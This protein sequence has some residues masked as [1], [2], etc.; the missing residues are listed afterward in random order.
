[1]I[2]SSFAISAEVSSSSNDI[3]WIWTGSADNKRWCLGIST[4]AS[5]RFDMRTVNGAPVRTSAKLLETKISHLLYKVG[6]D[7]RSLSPP[8]RHVTEMLV[9]DLGSKAMRWAYLMTFVGIVERA[10]MALGFIVLCIVVTTTRCLIM[11]TRAP[12]MSTMCR[13]W[14]W[15][16]SMDFYM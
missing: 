10:C 16:V 14:N 6:H 8:E 15:I 13:C 5:E 11:R 12:S 4:T 3:V 9:S 1:M 7:S 2:F